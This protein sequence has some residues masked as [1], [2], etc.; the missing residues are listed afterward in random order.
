LEAVVDHGVVKV[1]TRSEK[2]IHVSINK[3]K[4]VAYTTSLTE[5]EQNV[6]SPQNSSSEDDEADSPGSP[7]YGKERQQDVRMQLR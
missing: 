6:D 5:L 4:I 7:A 1:K 2:K 3:T